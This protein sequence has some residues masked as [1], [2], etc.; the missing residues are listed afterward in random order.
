MKI[1]DA[2]SASKFLAAQATW[3]KTRKDPR[4]TEDQ[5]K[6][7]K[8]ELQRH[9]AAVGREIRKRLALQ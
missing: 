7:A 2:P 4:A 8:A 9:G 1:S 3:N 6:R 5:K